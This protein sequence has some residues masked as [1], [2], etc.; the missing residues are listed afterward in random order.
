MLNRLRHDES[1]ISLMEL[2]VAG[3]MASIIA[4]AFLLVFS[5]FSRSVSLEEARAAALGEAQ[6]A[7]ADL[8]VE[9]RQAI[10][11]T[12]GAF[13]VASLDSAWPAPELVFY[14]DRARDAAGPERYRYYVSGCAGNRCDLMRDLT[15]ADAGG[16]PWTY[17]G[18]AH[19]ERVVANVL[20]DGESLFEGARWTTGSE[21]LTSSCDAATP[22]GFSL[23]KFVIRID[24]DPN[25]MAEEPLQVRHEVRLR[26]AP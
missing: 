5:S 4:T 23:V 19:S 26:N 15:I 21:V 2:M 1:G 11:L 8:A 10:P 17:T 16:P 24:P 13:A 18:T 25:S 3:A 22:C 14:S 9:L 12:D 6:A 7:S 20:T